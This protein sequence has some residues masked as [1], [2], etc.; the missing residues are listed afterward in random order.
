SE[1]WIQR[2]DVMEKRRVWAREI[3]AKKEDR[4]TGTIVRAVCE[5][6]RCQ[7]RLRKE[8]ST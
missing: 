3:M 2:E 4:R 6:C 5:G 1:R 7:G 8:F